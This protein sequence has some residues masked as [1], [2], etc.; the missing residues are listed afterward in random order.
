MVGSTGRRRR[1]LVAVA[2]VVV[3]VLGGIVLAVAAHRGGGYAVGTQQVWVSG[4]PEPGSGPYSGPVRL[5]ATL[6]L[7][8]GAPREPAVMLAHGFGGT[9]LDMDAEARRIAARGYV[10]LTWTARGFGRSGGL[11][12]LDSPTYEVADAS[13]LV[14]M[15]AT[16]PEVQL[17]GPGDPRVA[18]AG[19]SYGGA[20][21][22]LLAAYDHR[23]DAIIPQV[24]WNDLGH[25]FFPQSAVTS[26][27][28]RSPAGLDP[29]GTP[30]VFKK[31]WASLFFS[32]TGGSGGGAPSQSPSAPAVGKTPVDPPGSGTPSGCGR[33]VCGAA[34]EITFASYG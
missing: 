7:P 34:L 33:T 21:A 3:L 18:V 13:R 1:R 5:D 10:V 25:S 15:L 12:H 2:I 32:P 17:D 9:K 6:Y 19:A 23:I 26:T 16:R 29:V 14:D 27:T 8:Q 4:T 31:D 22:L 28:L 11:I 20:L 30:G 24:T